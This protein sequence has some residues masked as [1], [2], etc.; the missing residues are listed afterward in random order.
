MEATSAVTSKKP[1]KTQ[2][3][4]AGEAAPIKPSFA[5]IG[6]D[7]AHTAQREALLRELKAQGWNLSATAKELRMGT[8]S[9]VIRAIRSLGLEKEYEAAQQRR[10]VR[11]GKRSGD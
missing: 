9:T 11:P 3:A 2:P 5:E 6:R 4:A 7:A 8:A 10:D 1:P